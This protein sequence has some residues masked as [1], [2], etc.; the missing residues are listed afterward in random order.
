MPGIT[1]HAS[2]CSFLS[3]RGLQP[4]P[5]QL[6]MELSAVK[7]PTTVDGQISELTAFTSAMFCWPCWPSLVQSRRW[8]HKTSVERQLAANL[9]GRCLREQKAS[10]AHQGTW[11][12]EWCSQSAI[13]QPSLSRA[14]QS[15][16]HICL[17]G[18]HPVVQTTVLL[19]GWHQT[20]SKV[21][22]DTSPASN[23]EYR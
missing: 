20:Q 12:S 11:N 21:C 1:G 23:H 19:T 14:L 8:L 2:L 3:I 16:G 17:A 9:E 22:S 6:S 18:S 5:C 15:E 10:V 4:Q 7:F 13:A